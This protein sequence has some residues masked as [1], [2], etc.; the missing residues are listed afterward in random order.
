MNLFDG[1][2]SNAKD[3]GVDSWMTDEFCMEMCG[4][5]FFL[6]SLQIPTEKTN[7][8][9]RK[10]FFVMGKIVRRFSLIENFP[11]RIRFVADQQDNSLSSSLPIDKSN[12]HFAHSSR[13]TEKSS[14]FEQAKWICMLWMREEI[15]RA[16]IVVFLID[17]LTK[18][19]STDE[20]FVHQI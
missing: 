15:C 18:K 9:W 12:W 4:F 5:F 17:C 16:L 11:S 6:S 10:L 3:I 8:P 7:K 14:F 1:H 2:S 13:D 20:I 19:F